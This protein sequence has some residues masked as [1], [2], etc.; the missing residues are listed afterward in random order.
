[1]IKPVTPEKVNKTKQKQIP[2][3]VMQAFNTLIAKE[4]DGSSAR[5]QQKE[6]VSEILKNFKKSGTKIKG[7]KIFENNW[8]DVE[9]IYRG[10][11]WLV[12][13]DKPGYSEDYE[14]YWTFEK[15]I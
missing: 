2:D 15:A 1:M 7:E 5:I 12:E 9:N 6:V 3:Q 4:W 10:A 13:Y 8:L 14:A 11:G